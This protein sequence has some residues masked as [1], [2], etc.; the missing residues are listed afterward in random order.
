MDN[1]NALPAMTTLFCSN[2]VALSDVSPHH[3]D[4]ATAPYVILPSTERGI[5]S[6]NMAYSLPKI[7]LHE[8]VSPATGHTTDWLSKDMRPR[9]PV[10]NIPRPAKIPTALNI[11]FSDD[12]TS[13]TS[14]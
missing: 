12:E 13:L 2:P 5:V 7:V 9:Y 14:L 4:T 1:S 3:E 8:A 11:V 6:H 10:S